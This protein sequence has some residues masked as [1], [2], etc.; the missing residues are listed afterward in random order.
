MSEKTTTSDKEYRLGLDGFCKEC[1]TLKTDPKHA[2]FSEQDYQAW[3]SNLSEYHPEILLRFIRSEG[4]MVPDQLKPRIV[5][6][7]YVSVWADEGEIMSPATVNLATKEVTILESYDPTDLV[8]DDGELMECEIL[9]EE[10]V[11]IAGVKYPCMRCDELEQTDNT[12]TFW[13]K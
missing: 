3:H 2:L 1:E 9:K 10:Y 7:T 11:T 5:P 12:L 8:D 13:Y 4:Y 6:G